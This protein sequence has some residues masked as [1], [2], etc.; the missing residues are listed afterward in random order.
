MRYMR[1]NNCDWHERTGLVLAALCGLLD[2]AV[3]LFTL[4]VYSPSFRR[5]FLMS[6]FSI[7]FEKD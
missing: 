1:K 6:D 2:S 5:H 7:R 4:G 3:T